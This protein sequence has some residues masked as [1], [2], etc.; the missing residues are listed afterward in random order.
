MNRL[1]MKFIVIIALL[2]FAAPSSAQQQEEPYV[3]LISMDGFRWDY[4]QRGLTPHLDQ[5]RQRGVQALSLEPVFPSKT[6]PNHLAIITGMYPENHG[7][8]FNYFSDPF[9]DRSY[10]LRDTAA[11]RDPRWYL[12]EAFW[13]TAERQGIRCASY[14]WPGSEM[15]PEYR[16]PTYFEHYEHRRPYEK[17]V[18]G[19]IRWLQMPQSQRPHFITLYFDAVDS[20]SHRHG[21]QSAET[22]SAIVRVDRMV[23]LL[24]RRLQQIGMADSVNLIV[25]SD[26][27]M[28]DVDPQKVIY[29]DRLLGELS[30]E[31]QQSGPVMMLQPKKGE[32]ETVLQRLRKNAR[33]FRVFARSQVPSYW[34][35]SRHPFI[36]D[37]VLVADPGWSLLR[38]GQKLRIRATHG[39]DNHFMDMHG[40]FV[41]AGPAFK[42]G[43]RTGTLRNIDIY[44]LLC[45][46]FQI[47]PRQNIDGRLERIGF[48]LK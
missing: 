25:V 4:L 23:G 20:Q 13:E 30:C 33:H 22:D 48:V 21:T 17:R 36:W 2:L 43:Y 16:H 15:R 1:R 19:V 24:L 45:K 37:L 9:S 46:I 35:F 26:H 41:A 7:I 10:S 29:V 18:E 40:I 38:S 27:G 11:V 12:G 32:L 44:P 14:F 3:I 39:Y 5:L 42:K 31:S 8:L 28:T 6:F 47:F 34:H